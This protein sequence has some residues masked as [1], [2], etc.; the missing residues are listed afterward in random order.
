MLPLEV[1]ERFDTASHGRRNP[2][3]TMK[4]FFLA[5]LLAISGGLAQ[6]AADP[7]LSGFGVVGDGRA[8]D[9][10]AI[11]K[12]VDSGA[13]ALRF[14]RG[15]Y[16]LTQTVVVDL[17]KAGFTSLAADG[18]A[19]FVM[20]GAGPAFKLV[21]AHQGTADPKSFKPGVWERQRTPMVDGIEIVGAHP[22][23]DGIEA[24]GTMQ[25]TVSRVTV[26]EARHGIHLTQRNRNVIL[27]ECHLYHNRGI[28]VFY[29][30]VDL[31]QSNI[32]GCHISYNAG[33]GVV[34]RGGAVR[35]LQ[36]G[37]CDIEANQSQ[38]G[39]PTANVLLDCTDGS[40]AEVAIGGCT[41]QH[42]PFPGSA[43]IRFIGKGQEN[44][45]LYDNE[46]TRWGHLT[47]S[48]NVMSDV[49]VNVHLQ[50]AR[51]VAITGNSFGTAHE[52]DLLVEDCCDVVVGPNCFD[53]NPR[54]FS[55]GSALEANG[56]LLFRNSRD[57]TLSGLHVDGVRRQSG[58]IILEKCSGFNV[59]NCTILDSDGPGLLVRDV[60]G[61]LIGGC[62]IRDHRADRQSAPSMRVEG[63][64][65]NVIG[66]NLLDFGSES[67][68]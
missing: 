41:L 33:G 24:T 66:S 31:H 64:H 59:A 20:E 19:K 13:G 63:G 29:D 51:G 44:S 43:N 25:L 23:S 6:A 47:I 36:I 67:K 68:P 9:T 26:R 46:T 56:G 58:A 48:N 40:V 14:P 28:G 30:R 16:R 61:S 10:A 54:Y 49:Q 50:H 45:K 53:R 37:T 5:L 38:D 1:R 42:S 21:G 55:A 18:V 17:D 65:N 39:P 35:N 3:I 7:G 12:A 15:T 11:Q 8:D 62:L 2:N 32:V 52:R 34:T 57:C 27:S 22:E 60:S 4:P